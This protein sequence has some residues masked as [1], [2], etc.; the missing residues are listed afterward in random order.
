LNLER[1]SPI[2]LHIPES[3]QSASEPFTQSKVTMLSLDGHCGLN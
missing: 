3:F 2:E 1:A